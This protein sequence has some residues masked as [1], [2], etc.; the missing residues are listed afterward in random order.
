M[1]W[2]EK[3]ISRREFELNRARKLLKNFA[4]GFD[5]K[6][7]LV[8]SADVEFS[9]LEG[10]KI[11]KKIC[12]ADFA[13]PSEY[14]FQ[15]IEVK[16]NDLYIKHQNPRDKTICPFPSSSWNPFSDSIE[17]AI[18][19]LKDWLIGKYTGYYKDD[20]LYYEPP[21]FDIS[22]KH[23]QHIYIPDDCYEVNGEDGTLTIGWDDRGRVGLV[24]SVKARNRQWMK[25]SRLNSKFSEQFGAKGRGLWFFIADE[26]TRTSTRMVPRTYREMDELIS[27]VTGTKFELVR[28][29]ADITA[30]ELKTG[31]P[32]ALIYEHKGKKYWQFFRYS[33]PTIPHD[34]H[35]SNF[36]KKSLPLGKINEIH[37]HL[38]DTGIEYVNSFALR[39]EDLFSRVK[40]NKDLRDLRFCIIGLG[41]VGSI[42][43]IELAKFG[44]TKFDL[45]D[46][47]VIKPGNPCRHVVNLSKV[48]MSK[49]AAIGEELIQRNPYAD[50]SF[51]DKSSINIFEDKEIVE[52]AIARGDIIIIATG[53]ANSSLFINQ[54]LIKHQK[55]A[56]YLALSYMAKMGRLL[57]LDPAKGAC[58]RCFSLYETKK[59]PR[60]KSFPPEPIE[61]KI[62]DHGCWD[63][64][65]PATG[66]DVGFYSNLFV[67][68]IISI[69]SS[70]Q[71]GPN[72]YLISNEL[73]ENYVPQIKTE[74]CAFDRHSDCE[75]CQGG[76]SQNESP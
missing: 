50:I 38:L 33:I 56:F 75:F 46:F 69:L 53:D 10:E 11:V 26:P 58:F 39:P 49:V 25:H 36:K 60:F 72:H 43:A 12:K 59:D 16:P 42:V 64:T 52:T 30:P 14:P 32:I 45:I 62:I 37:K 67:K 8:L 61:E 76:H 27:N 44:I 20:S 24:T 48:G 34:P 23:I 15:P 65:V 31:M 68:E 19:R 66:F 35:E 74:V 22:A 13:Y 57:V 6:K 41:A 54:L 47:D 29:L 70:T 73:N 18:S 5:D 3:N 21:W 9:Y 17:T 63:V 40:G 1:E 2:Y 7:R 28:H 71:N 51:D 4:S 55:K